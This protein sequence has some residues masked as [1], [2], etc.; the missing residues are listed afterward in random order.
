VRGSDFTFQEE[1]EI[2]CCKTLSVVVTQLINECLSCGRQ[3]RM[4]QAGMV[5]QSDVLNRIFLEELEEVC[6]P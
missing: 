1:H 5:K 3:N 6:N 4:Q 2:K